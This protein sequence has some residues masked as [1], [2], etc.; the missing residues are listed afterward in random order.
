MTPDQR[1]IIDLLALIKLVVLDAGG[2]VDS[3]TR[4]E[5][6]KIHVAIS[7]LPEGPLTAKQMVTIPP[8][9]RRNGPTVLVTCKVLV[10]GPFWQHKGSRIKPSGVFSPLEAKTMAIL[11]SIESRRM[12]PSAPRVNERRAF[13]MTLLC[14]TL[15]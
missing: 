15:V 8:V 9:S 10:A 11:S 7:G 6:G 13:R 3:I 1:P 14:S 5:E 4:P 2:Q 12:V